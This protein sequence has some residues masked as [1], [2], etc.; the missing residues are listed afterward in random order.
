MFTAKEAREAV[1]EY[2]KRQSKNEAKK[3]AAITKR[4]ERSVEI[5]S[6]N[7]IDTYLTNPITDICGNRQIIRDGVIES[8]IRDGY[9]AF[10]WNERFVINW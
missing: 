6:R 3:I 10:I 1:K 8:L 5:R 4:L 9:E 2:E 7:G